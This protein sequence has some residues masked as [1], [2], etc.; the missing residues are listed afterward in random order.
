MHY[1]SNIFQYLEE[2][3]LTLC[4]MMVFQN[5]RN[6]PCNMQLSLNNS[7]I[8]N[9]NLN[10]SLFAKFKLLIFGIYMHNKRN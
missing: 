7:D 10:G 6:S 8:F 4:S 5:H 2:R 9:F 3:L 1:F